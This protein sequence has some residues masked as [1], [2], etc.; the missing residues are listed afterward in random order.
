MSGY[1]LN[2][3]LLE[4]EHQSDFSG[5]A[6]S[7]RQDIIELGL[8]GMAGFSSSPTL[9]NKVRGALGAILLESGSQAVRERRP[10]DWSPSC[11]A[12]VFFGRKPQIQIGPYRSEITKPY[13]LYAGT[14]GQDLT[15][16]MAVFGFASD[17]VRELTPALIQALQSR[18][19]WPHLAKDAHNFIPAKIEV[20]APNIISNASIELPRVPGE[21]E[22]EFLT[23]LDAERGS[24]EDRP[25][26]IFERLALRVFMLARWQGVK[27]EVPWQELEQ[28]WLGCEYVLDNGPFGGAVRFGG[29]K[30]K[31]SVAANQTI[32]VKG[33][34]ERLWPLLVI[35]ERVNIGRGA[36]I[37][38]GRYHINKNSDL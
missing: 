31:N 36:S 24:L 27:I 35:G 26:L 25:Y 9:L 23:P 10:C 19:R 29:H 2:R 32:T 5:L 13:V 33:D 7:W 14:K 22:I 15:I 6:Q 30:F 3:R 4:P 18:V 34:L 28:A 20:L 38:L 37:G 1:A 21:V 8:A 17:W 16:R 12:E 11:A